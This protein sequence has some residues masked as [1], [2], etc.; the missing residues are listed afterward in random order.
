MKSKSVI[1]VN[2]KPEGTDDAAKCLPKSDDVISEWFSQDHPDR[3]R[4]TNWSNH[5]QYE[6]YS[7]TL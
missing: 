3:L 7:K 2:G 4:E 1:D 5:N 6:E